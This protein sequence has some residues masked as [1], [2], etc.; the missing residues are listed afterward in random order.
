VSRSFE[1]LQLASVRTFQQPVQKTLNVQQASGFLS[2]AQLWEDRCN[3]PGDVD[4]CPDALIH[5][6]SIAIQIQTSGRRSSWSGRACINRLDDHPPGPVHE[7]SIWKLLAPDVRPSGRQGTTIRTRLRNRK[8]FQ[9]NSRT[10][11]HT[12]VRLN[13]PCLPSGRRLVFVK[14]DAHLNRQPINRGP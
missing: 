7:A 6:A 1:L 9:Q 14:P 8:E 12:V 11:N 5:K 13:D 3:R 10:I 4:S 2:K